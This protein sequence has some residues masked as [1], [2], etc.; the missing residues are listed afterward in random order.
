ML[1]SR[2]QSSIWYLFQRFIYLCYPLFCLIVISLA[3]HYYFSGN[4]KPDLC[5]IEY[6]TWRNILRIYARPLQHIQEKRQGLHIT[7]VVCAVVYIDYIFRSGMR[8][9]IYIFIDLCNI[10]SDYAI[11]EMKW[12]KLFKRMRNRKL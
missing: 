12:P 6:P 4:R 8:L 7:T 2:S 10:F 1:R 9:C 5:R 3:Y 11:R